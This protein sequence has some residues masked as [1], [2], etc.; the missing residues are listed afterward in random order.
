MPDP[1]D[2]AVAGNESHL[3]RCDTK[4]SLLLGLAV[5]LLAVTFSTAK[6]D[7]PLPATIANRAALASL[8]IATG[9][10]LTT[11]RP[12]IGGGDR[13]SWPYWSRCSIEEIHSDL[14]DGTDRRAAQVHALS[15]LVRAKYKR[16]RRAVDCLAVGT[17]LLVAASYLTAL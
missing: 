6:P 14:T 5:G 17:A 9:L 13:S 16:L 2:Q 10:L 11:V 4:A 3:N 12:H 1:L 7:L 8:A 15:R